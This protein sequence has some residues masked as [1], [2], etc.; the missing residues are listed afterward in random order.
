M[1]KSAADIIALARKRGKWLPFLPQIC[2]FQLNRS[3]V[4]KPCTSWSKWQAIGRDYQRRIAPLQAKYLWLGRMRGNPLIFWSWEV[5][6]TNYPLEEWIVTLL[7]PV[8]PFTFPL[9]SVSLFMGGRYFIPNGTSSMLVFQVVTLWDVAWAVTLLLEILEACSWPCCWKL[10]PSDV[11][12]QVVPACWGYG[13]LQVTKHPKGPC[14]PED[15]CFQSC[16]CKLGLFCWLGLQSS[17]AIW[18][19]QRGNYCLDVCI[20]GGLEC[21]AGDHM[22]LSAGAVP[23]LGVAKR[24]LPAEVITIQCTMNWSNRE[25]M[26]VIKTLQIKSG[27]ELSPS[28]LERKICK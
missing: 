24:H 27:S 13:G 2:F 11:Y 7:Y 23:N 8:F 25:N 19:S 16:V 14:E 1:S 12:L 21:G 28:G 10:N 15:S 22:L 6:P 9:D 17:W 3:S 26:A 5:L 18:K 4:K 20:L